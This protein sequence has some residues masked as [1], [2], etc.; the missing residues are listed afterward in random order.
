MY[1]RRIAA[2]QTDVADV[3]DVAGEGSGYDAVRDVTGGY[4]GISLLPGTVE[5]PRLRRP[6]THG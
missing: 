3:A 4:S 2:L 6:A 5:D 1:H